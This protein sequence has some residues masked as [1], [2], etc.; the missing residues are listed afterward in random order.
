[1]TKYSQ[2]AASLPNAGAKRVLIVDDEP[3]ILKVVGRVMDLGGYE[4][5]GV[6][7]GAAALSAMATEHWDLVITDR[8]MPGMSGDDLA[9]ALKQRAPE[10]PVIMLTGFPEAVGRRELFEAVV[11]KPFDCDG[12]LA[13]VAQALKKAEEAAEARRTARGR[14]R[15]AR[16]VPS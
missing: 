16:T 8:A 14:S 15:L 9:L 7:N 4:S 6:L 13:V 12:L 10:M 1:M 11:A 2:N 5:A 3:A